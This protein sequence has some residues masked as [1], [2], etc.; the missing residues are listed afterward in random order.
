MIIFA[1]RLPAVN[2]LLR[3]WGIGRSVQDSHSRP[4]RQSHRRLRS[5]GR[6]ARHAPARLGLRCLADVPPVASDFAQLSKKWSQ[7]RASRAPP[8][9]LLSKALKAAV[10]MPALRCQA[11]NKMLLEMML[12]SYGFMTRRCTSGLDLMPYGSLRPA[13]RIAWPPF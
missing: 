3:C 5:E 13:I 1:A 11:E 10:A 4:R 7:T 6:E 12:E 9:T 2:Q 8:T